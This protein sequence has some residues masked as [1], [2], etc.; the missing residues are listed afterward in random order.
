MI[1][2]KNRI[3]KRTRVIVFKKICT[4]YFMFDVD[5]IL[6]YIVKLLYTLNDIICNNRSNKVKQNVMS[7][8][9][10][11]TLKNEVM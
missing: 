1:H 2:N 8:K 6:E 9:I 11:S 10:R 3:L 7:Q 4:F 5:D